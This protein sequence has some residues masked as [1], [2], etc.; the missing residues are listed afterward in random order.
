M[1]WTL[2]LF[3]VYDSKVLKFAGAELGEISTNG[4]IESNEVNPGTVLLSFADTKGISGEGDIIKLNFNVVGAA[5]TSTKI[6]LEARAY[7]VDLKD[8]AVKTSEGTITV[9]EKKQEST[10]SNQNQAPSDNN[11]LYYIIAGAVV[12]VIVLLLLLKRRRKK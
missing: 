9:S 4:I 7:G 5:R 2:G 6:K 10:N 1:L 12:V 11:L 3:I 8:I